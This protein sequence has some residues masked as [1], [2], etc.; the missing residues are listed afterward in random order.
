MGLRIESQNSNVI[1]T[2]M[3]NSIGKIDDRVEEKPLCPYTGNCLIARTQDLVA[4]SSTC[5][6][7]PITTN[8]KHKLASFSLNTA[9]TK[10][11][12]SPRIHSRYG[13]RLFEMDYLLIGS[14][15]S[16]STA[17]HDFS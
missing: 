8:F 7:S 3:E 11:F 12:V 5:N 4:T 16:V 9:Y 17:E 6:K 13:I 10:I 2:A 14:L 1:L 15:G